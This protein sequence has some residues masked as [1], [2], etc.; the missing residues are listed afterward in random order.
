MY[1]PRGLDVDRDRVSPPTEL[2]AR[3]AVAAAIVDADNFGD[4][5]GLGMDRIRLESIVC[6][7]C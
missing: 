2:R 4:G 6:V 5:V 3:G 7:C 1:E